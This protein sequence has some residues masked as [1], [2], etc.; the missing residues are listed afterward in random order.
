MRVFCDDADKGAEVMIDGKFKGECPVDVGVPAGTVKLRVVKKVDATHESVFE[1]R[2]H[3]VNAYLAQLG[4]RS[5]RVYVKGKDSTQPAGTAKENSRA[6][7][8]A[9]GTQAN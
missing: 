5:N 9:I 6:E 7:L 3:T 4:I 1:Q 2:A 8:E